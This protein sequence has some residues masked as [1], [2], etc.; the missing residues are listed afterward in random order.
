VSDVLVLC[1]HA[2]SRSWPAALS[3]TPDALREQVR[4]LLES[5]YAP[6]TF[7]AAVGTRPEARTLAV[8]FDDAYRSTIELGL[9]VLGELG[10]PAT[11]FVPSGFVDSPEPMAWAGIDGWLD[12]P[13]RSELRCMT[14]G[15]LRELSD[16]GWE[17]GSHTR[18][19]P[20][21]TLLSDE[22]L[23]EQLRSSRERLED[24]M[25]VEC[26]SIAYPYGDADR[27]VAEAAR[28]QGYRSGA[29][30]IPYH[31]GS[32]PMLWPR[33]G[34]YHEDGSRRF[35]LKVSPLARRI[36]LARMRYRI[37]GGQHS[38]GPA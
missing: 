21:L 3:V 5:G 10:V 12:G 6:A 14:A 29:G 30:L 4:G 1:Y 8:T 18:S 28:T 38:A 9:P 25:G 35:A 34:V 19:H 17:I 26:R 16:A 32:D 24:L 7:S 37:V 11:V 22:E 33:V 15:Q 13:H 31:S 23:A 20:R 36:G 2:V 27:R